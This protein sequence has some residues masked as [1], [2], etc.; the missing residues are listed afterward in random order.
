MNVNRL[1]SQISTNKLLC[2]NTLTL[3]INSLTLNSLL[4]TSATLS[5][6]FQNDYLKSKQ[7]ESN[8]ISLRLNSNGTAAA[9]TTTSTDKSN[10][11]EMN[12]SLKRMETALQDNILIRQAN[13]K[14]KHLNFLQEAEK[15]PTPATPASGSKKIYDAYIDPYVKLF[16]LNN[17]AAVH[18][19]Y[20]PSAWAIIGSASYLHT[21]P[22]FY[23]LGLFGLGA[24]AMRTAGCIINDIW[25]RN[26][27]KHVERVMNSD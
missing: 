8:K 10:L 19:V 3:S 18:L 14:L 15:K 27:D 12:K 21:T 20:W 17:L 16:R 13:F 23:M 6:Q 11:E 25:D 7:L 26:I 2:K 5:N 9:A 24:I 22:D 1:I 4:K